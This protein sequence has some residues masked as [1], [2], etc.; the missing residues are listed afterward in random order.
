VPTGGATIREISK[1][2]FSDLVFDDPG[3]FLESIE[4]FEVYVVRRYHPAERIRAFRAMLREF[5]DSCEPTW[6]PCLD[7][8]PDYH[9]INDRYPQSWVKARMHAFYF[10]R[11]G[12][13]RNLFDEFKEI[14]EIKNFLGQADKA[15]HY[16]ALP[17]SGVISRLVSHQYPRGGGCL[18]EHIDPVNPFARIQTIIQASQHGSD[19][20]SG[21]LYMRVAEGAPAV[22][23]DEHTEPGDLMVLSPNVRHG[24]LPIDP[25]ERLDW[26]RDDGRWMILPVIIRSDYNM[27]PATKPRSVAPGPSD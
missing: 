20:R 18:D 22:L 17:S 13:Q 8:V 15:A 3:A 9:R 4:R 2:E 7:G 11:W 25:A 23:L 5:R 6:H 26:E 10:H 19:F 24:V 27:D 16:D 1:R 14:F 12:S 21:G